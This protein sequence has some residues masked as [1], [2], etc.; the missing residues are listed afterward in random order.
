MTRNLPVGRIQKGLWDQRGITLMELLIA[1]VIG[2]FVLA[3]FTG[4]DLSRIFLT[5]EANANAGFQTN[6][7]YSL[8]HISR[9]LLDADRVVLVSSSNMQI[10]RVV[11][12]DLNSAD[13][14]D[15]TQ[16]RYDAGAGTIQLYQQTEAGCSNYLLAENITAVQF[17]FSD[18]SITPPG[19]EP[20]SGQDNN[21]LQITV[22]SEDPI[23]HRQLTM[24]STVAIRN[25]AHSNVSSGLSDILPP[26]GACT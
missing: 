16:Y 6:V 3:A 12:T 22:T 7:A 19:G 4:I 13:S 9:E 18:E 24:R 2:L 8:G 11:G 5:N 10:R 17:A 14:Y 15:W 1:V 23:T 21:M 26:P 20:L 25:G